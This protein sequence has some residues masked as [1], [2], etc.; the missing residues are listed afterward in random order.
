MIAWAALV[1]ALLNLAI[2]AGLAVVARR[3]YKQAAPMLS[4]LSLGGSVAVPAGTEP[5]A[6]ASSPAGDP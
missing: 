4:M 5:T 6:A 3:L 2:W 1:L